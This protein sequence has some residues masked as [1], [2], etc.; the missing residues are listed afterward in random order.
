M[1]LIELVWLRGMAHRPRDLV[2]CFGTD[3]TRCDDPCPG[4][5][6]GAGGHDAWVVWALRRFVW[7]TMPHSGPHWAMQRCN[8][9]KYSH[10]CDL[11]PGHGGA[12]HVCEPDPPNEG[13]YDP[14]DPHNTSCFAWKLDDPE[15]FSNPP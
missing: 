6:R 1:G 13:G 10:G 11:P 12:W 5:G 2:T 4:R 3:G 8:S 15:A 14:D 9:F 7:E